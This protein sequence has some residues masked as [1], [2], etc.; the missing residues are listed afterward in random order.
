MFEAIG[1]KVEKLKR[2][3]IAFL[4]LSGLKSGEYRYLNTKEV[5]RLYSLTK[6]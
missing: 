1:Y 4:D 2:E 3:K 5:K 6:K